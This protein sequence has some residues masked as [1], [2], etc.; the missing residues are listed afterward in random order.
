MAIQAYNKILIFKLPLENANKI[1]AKLAELYEKI[2]NVRE[3]NHIKGLS[4]TA[5]KMAAEEQAKKTAE[6]EKKKEEEKLKGF[7]TLD[8]F[9]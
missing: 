7:Y 6:E 8:E 4:N 9:S 1:R 2:G 5:T 3:A